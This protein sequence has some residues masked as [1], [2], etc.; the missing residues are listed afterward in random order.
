MLR[1]LQVPAE[2][3]VLVHPRVN[4]GHDAVGP[5]FEQNKGACSNGGGGGG[6]GGGKGGGPRQR[7]RLSL[8]LVA[9]CGAWRYHGSRKEGG[10]EGG[11]DTR[12][13]RKPDAVHGK[14]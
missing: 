7:E 14:P 4:H 10:K 8:A 9:D 1:F 6:G 3:C 11:R 12:H 13:G 2:V 5:I